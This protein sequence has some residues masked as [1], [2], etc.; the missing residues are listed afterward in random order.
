M[1][2]GLA[3]GLCLWAAAIAITAGGCSAPPRQAADPEVL[4]VVGPAGASLNPYSPLLSQRQV[5]ELVFQGLVDVDEQGRLVPGLCEQLPTTSNGGVA[6]DLLTMTY[7]LKADS[8]WHDGQ[9]VT[10]HDVVFTWELLS[11]RVLTD[12]PS[13]PLAQVESVVAIDEQTVRFT[14]SEP[15]SELGWNLIPYVL[16]EHLLAESP[17]IPSDPYWLSPVGSGAYRVSD[18]FNGASVLLAP[19]AE[20][21]P[22]L[23]IVFSQTAGD[24]RAAFDS[25]GRAVW[26]YEAVPARGSSEE[27]A[28]A[29]SVVRTAWV[30][31]EANGRVGEDVRLRRVV[32]DVLSED[33]ASRPTTA[34]LDASLD[35]AGWRRSADDGIRLRAGRRL[36]LDIVTPA[37]APDQGRRLDEVVSRLRALGFDASYRPEALV[38]LGTYREDSPLTSGE[39]DVALTSLWLGLGQ[40]FPWH[41]VDVPSEGLPGGLNS[42]RVADQDL[43]RLYRQLQES[44]DPAMAADVWRRALARVEE[45][46]HVAW[47]P[48]EKS[49]V[50][51]RGVGGVTAHPVPGEALQSASRW[52]LR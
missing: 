8:R 1:S 42:G 24:A 36:V 18:R 22:V 48:E 10:A 44:T 23:R 27:E 47:G 37:L 26:V 4:V 45:Q 12:D 14:F 5:G 49:V 17:H 3:R 15:S 16:P 50:V 38:P 31:N 2:R 11:S 29:A 52:T 21:P 9:P 6:E 43:D 51:T 19:V 25:A 20:G 32:R 40:P 39:F 7:V 34:S 30:F 41:S 35:A 13:K 46:A 33:D 28:L